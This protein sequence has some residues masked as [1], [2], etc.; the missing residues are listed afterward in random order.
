M[1]RDVSKVLPKKTPAPGGRRSPVKTVL[2]VGGLDPSNGAGITKDME[3]FTAM[4]MNAV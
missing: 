4:G 1:E 2:T 3:I